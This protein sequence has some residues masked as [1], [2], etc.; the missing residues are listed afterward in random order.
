M[1]APTQVHEIS[2]APAALGQWG[3]R[4]L[5]QTCVCLPLP[6][7]HRWPAKGLPASREKAQ[8]SFPGNLLG[9]LWSQPHT[10]IPIHMRFKGQE[11]APQG[12]DPQA[13]SGH[14]GSAHC[15]LCWSISHSD[16]A[17]WSLWWTPTCT[18]GLPSY[19]HGGVWSPDSV[20]R[21]WCT[22]VETHLRHRCYHA[23]V[24]GKHVA[25]FSNLAPNISRWSDSTGEAR[26]P[27]PPRNSRRTGKFLFLPWRL[28]LCWL[29][30][31][32][33]LF[34]ATDVCLWTCLQGE[35][36]PVGDAGFPGPEGPSGKP[37]S[38]FHYLKVL[39]IASSLVTSESEIWIHSFWGSESRSANG[40]LGCG[41]PW[42]PSS[43]W[44]Y[45]K[46]PWEQWGL[47]F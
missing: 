24:E 27:R 8:V 7:S 5:S 10:N 45:L 39:S 14:L 37:V 19:L 6:L 31:V 44:V 13:W 46:S 25:L 38:L 36:G 1:H 16:L 11:V 33:K 41:S 2:G 9:F 35:R 3:P 21:G 17:Q 23:G 40:F 43:L 47:L 15:Y 22:S 28:S 20:Q 12:Q 32:L 29:H 4:M 34:L 18:E 26:S 42:G 30:A